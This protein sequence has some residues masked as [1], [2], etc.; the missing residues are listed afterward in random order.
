MDNEERVVF[1]T[2]IFIHTLV[3]ITDVTVAG[4][5][6][7]DHAV[8]WVPPCA[9]VTTRLHRIC[10]TRE[11]LLRRIYAEHMYTPTATF[12]HFESRT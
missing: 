11:D 6:N 7:G 4:Q 9:A 12:F 3:V 2:S 5:A 10:F 8:Y 1:L